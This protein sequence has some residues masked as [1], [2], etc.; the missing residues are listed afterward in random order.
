[1]RCRWHT[2]LKSRRYLSLNTRGRCL[3]HTREEA[4]PVFR[5][6]RVH[7]GADSRTPAPDSRLRRRRTDHV[8]AVPVPT[9]TT[10]CN[11]HRAY[12]H[13]D[14]VALCFLL[15]PHLIL[16]LPLA[17]SFPNSSLSRSHLLSVV[18][19]CSLS[20][21]NPSIPPI[22][23]SLLRFPSS[24]PPPLSAPLNPFRLPLISSLAPHSSPHVRNRALPLP[25]HNSAG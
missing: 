6:I 4:A 1:M 25:P 10:D 3:T 16:S 23:Q 15:S 24:L 2:V 22:T 20:H 13:L 12:E 19:G 7:A 11:Y 18:L 8:P 9:A 14:C 21:L 5:S 17:P